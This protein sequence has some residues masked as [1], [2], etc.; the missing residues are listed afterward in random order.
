MRFLTLFVLLISFTQLSW[1]ATCTGTCS[2][3]DG[4]N[5]CR[6]TAGGVCTMVVG[7][8]S[9][10]INNG[11]GYDH[12]I[13]AKDG[14]ESW[15]SFSNNR[16]PG[17]TMTCG[18][19]VTGCPAVSPKS[20][21]VGSSTC[22]QNLSAGPV[23]NQP[24]LDDSSAPTTG[25]ATFQC[26]ADGT[27]SQLSAT[28][29]TAASSCPDNTIF[30]GSG[31][32]GPVTSGVVGAVKTVNATNKTGQVQVECLSSGSW[33][34]T[35]PGT[36]YDSCAGISDPSWNVGGVTC[37]AIGTTLGTSPHGPGPLVQSTNANSGN[38]TFNCNNGTWEVQSPTCSTAP[39][40]YASCP[41]FSNPSWSVSGNNCSSTS[42]IGSQPHGTNFGV[43]DSSGRGDANYSC[44]NG[45]WILNAGATCSPPA[46]MA[47][48]N[49]GHPNIWYDDQNNPTAECT[50][51]G[52]VNYTNHPDGE[53]IT[54]YACG[55]GCR[56]LNGPNSGMYYMDCGGELIMKCIN[57]SMQVQSTTCLPGGGFM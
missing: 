42:S 14:T 9:C 2:V 46:G 5:G 1:S 13:G 36:C 52:S 12:F 56:Y 57:G 54:I 29:T 22:S 47:C 48:N 32:S 25:Q 18:A 51:C 40:T 33:M 49:V 31:C 6:L 53:E 43:S 21:T 35:G 16:A 45:T 41:P 38:A 3:A 30:W 34:A 4:G 20:W 55:G 10:Q 44:N 24:L 23:G 27:W 26:M 7:S 17:V 19:V 15:A 37:Q 11:T 50:E 28:C 39:P 8:T